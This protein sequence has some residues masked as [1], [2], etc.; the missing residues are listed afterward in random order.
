MTQPVLDIQQLHL[1]FPGF[2][3][4]VHALNNVSLQINRGEIVGLVG[5]SGSGKSVTAMLIMRLLPT[6]S[7]C[8]HR[9][10]ISLLGDD[11][12]N[13]RE[14][15]LRQWRGARVAMIFQEPMTA[16]NPTL[17]IGL[18]MMDVIRH[19]QPISRREARAKAIAL[20]EEMQIPDAVEVMS[21]YPFELSGGMRQRVM[22]ALAFSCEPQLI[23]A[24]EPTT[25]L[26]VTVQLQVLRLL[27]HK[28][29]ASGTAVLFISHDMVVVSQLCDSVYVMYAGSVIESGVTADIIHHPRHPYTIGLL[30]CAP[31]HGVP[32]QP[33]PAIPGTVPNLTHLPEGCAFRDR[34]Y[35][36]GAQCENVPALTACGDNNQRCACWYPQQEVISVTLLTL[37]DVH[38]NF[39]ARKNWL[40]KTTEHVHAINGID[41]QIRRGETLG[42]VGESGCGKSTLAQLLMG[43]L[44]PSHGQYIRSGSQRIMQMVFQDPLSSLN[45]RLPVW[46]I[47]TEPLWIAK[48]SSEQQRRALAEELAVQV[49]IRPEYLDRLPHAFSG[50]QRQRIAIARALSSQPDV[51]VLDEPTSALDI[52]VQAQILNLLVTLQVNRGLT[53]V[54][55]SHNVSV[56]RHM[57]DRVAVMYLGQIVELGD[58][59]QVLTAP[60]HPYTRLLLDSLPAIDKPLEE[61]WALRKTDLPGNRTLPQ[62][63]FFYERCPLATHG[64]EVRQSLT[65]REDG[66]EIRC[67]R[68]L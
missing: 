57:S 41:L 3:G 49:G 31:E 62:G 34:C 63:C 47:I 4:D 20:L 30:Q 11:V 10:Q 67:W 19:H 59:Q 37:R 65:I 33:L 42:I 16:L 39:P 35:A 45:P 12:L 13:A 66:R 28:A 55:I 56:I 48:R 27:K 2:N 36:A 51:I 43:M 61:E 8:V 58:A 32:R 44:Q 22:I 17:R 40:G 18:Q 53:Y 26:D 46:R 1:S 23:I 14:K 52:S 50:G 5:E 21:R 38:I 25:A 15:Q 68:A 7:Y 24:D 54:L 9:G 64:C 60:A 6:G 29:R